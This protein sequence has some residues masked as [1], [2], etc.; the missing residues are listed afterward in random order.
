VECS[1]ILLGWFDEGL[2]EVYQV[3]GEAP[4]HRTVPKDEA[5]QLLSE[6]VKWTSIE[7]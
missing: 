3:L 1:R 5:R 6:P 4:W 2:I 7:V